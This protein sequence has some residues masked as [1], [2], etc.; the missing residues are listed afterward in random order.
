MMLKAIP[1]V[2]SLLSAFLLFFSNCIQAS[3]ISVQDTAYLHTYGGSGSETAKAVILTADSGFALCGSTNAYGPGNSSVYVVKTDS[4]GSRLWSAVLGGTQIDRGTGIVQTPDKGYLICGLS[5]SFGSNGYD[6]YLARLD[7]SGNLLWQKSTGGND[8]DFFY[9]IKKLSDDRYTVYG[10]TYS[11]AAG[12]SDAW[13]YCINLNGDLIWEQR[14]GS[15]GDDA[16]LGATVFGSDVFYCGYRQNITTLKKEAWLFKADTNGIQQFSKTYQF[17]D[18]DEFRCIAINSGGQL[19]LGG[20][21]KFQDSTQYNNLLS[22]MDTSGVPFWTITENHPQN[23]FVNAILW[24]SRNEIVITGQ[25]DPFGFGKKSMH[26]MRFDENGN[27]LDA[28]SFGGAEDEEGFAV[29]LSASGGLALAGYTNSYGNGNEDAL[30]VLVDS[31]SLNNGYSYSVLPF[32]ETLSPI[33]VFDLAADH[34]PF[35]YPNPVNSYFQINEEVSG[36]ISQARLWS[37]EGQL[38][39]IVEPDE[40]CKP[41]YIQDLINGIY[42]LEITNKKHQRRVNKIVVLKP[43]NSKK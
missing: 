31:D 5:N 27:F 18:A 43:Q 41:I 38:M 40:F 21:T 19:L 34:T 13:I 9:G 25:K 42:F 20:S 30:L 8:W 29:T 1:P 24:N 6:G 22:R 14:L 35:V 26:S 12:G 3:S 16:F 33:G 4:Q 39:R 2:K 15:S 32:L 10:E 7:A 11:G 28:H 17:R 36:I 37:S 23:N